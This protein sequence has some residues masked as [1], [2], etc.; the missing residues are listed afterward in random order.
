MD[1]E[2][3]FIIVLEQ[4]PERS[5]ILGELVDIELMIRFGDDSVGRWSIVHSGTT[6]RDK[7]G[8]FLMS[9]YRLNGA[10]DVYKLDVCI[11]F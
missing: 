1:A 2:D 6:S 8:L 3:V 10:G 7:E 9:L 5:L 4:G 11:A